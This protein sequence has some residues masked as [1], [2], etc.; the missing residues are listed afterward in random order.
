[1]MQT[2]GECLI[3]ANA[4]NEAP[5]KMFKFAQSEIKIAYRD[6]FSVVKTYAIYVMP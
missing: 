6:A 2:W 3:T 5:Q 1:M 4:F